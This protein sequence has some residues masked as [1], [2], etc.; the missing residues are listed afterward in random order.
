MP[1][2]LFKSLSDP[3]RIK[4]IKILRG[5]EMCAC[6][7]PEKVNR[8]QPTVSQHLK[9]LEKSGVLQSRRDGREI[10]YSIA[11]EKVFELIEIAGKI[12][13]RGD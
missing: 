10:L 8:A 11:D 13:N 12:Q 3:T 4:I 9:I 1:I 6:E 2:D 7:I 5:K